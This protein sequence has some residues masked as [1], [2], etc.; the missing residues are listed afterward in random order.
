MATDGVAGVV[1]VVVGVSVDG[2]GSWEER[3]ESGEHRHC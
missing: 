3:G 1:F 2:M